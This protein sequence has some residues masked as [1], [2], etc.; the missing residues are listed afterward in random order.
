[1][2]ISLGK[3][4]YVALLMVLSIVTLSQT[5]FS[6][7]MTKF[8][9]EN[10]GLISYNQLS[11]ARPLHVEGNRIKNDLGRV[12]C[13]RGWNKG[14]RTLETKEFG[15][16]TWQR[17]EQSKVDLCLEKMKSYGANCIRVGYNFWSWINNYPTPTEKGTIIYRECI[18][19]MITRAEQRGIYVI[20]CPWGIYPKD[21][22]IHGWNGCPPNDAG[23]QGSM[24]V[25]GFDPYSTNGHEGLIPN[26]DAFTNL[27]VDVVE[28]LGGHVNLIVEFYNEPWASYTGT[29]YA[30][31][32]Q[33]VWQKTINAIRE[34]ETEKGYVYH[35]ILV[36][37]TSNLRYTALSDPCSNFNWYWTNPLSDPANNLVYSQH[38]YRYHGSVGYQ[39][40]LTSRPYTYEELKRIYQEEK[41]EELSK[42]VPIVIGEVGAYIPIDN[43]EP[44]GT[45][46]LWMQNT[47]KIFNEW[48]LGYLGWAWW[49]ANTGWQQI[50]SGSEQTTGGIVNKFGQLLV[51]AIKQGAGSF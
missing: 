45:E 16:A 37:L 48:G 18:E 32:W 41:L 46:Y 4:V 28:V 44:V 12:I 50:E 47:L 13:L 35:L 51:D 21:C 40:T 2:P 17:Y 39:N 1:M 15:W 25:M 31:L 38:C 43:T 29:Y 27:I 3:K 5:S 49:D 42:L 36:Q 34:K 20:L 6:L 33:S 26:A 11:L 14:G 10:S 22:P 23:G 19:D 24:D 9:I 8:T 30:N 7:M